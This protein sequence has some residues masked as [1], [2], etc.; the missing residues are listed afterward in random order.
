VG[1]GS[2]WKRVFKKERRDHEGL[3]FG[4]SALISGAKF[5]VERVDP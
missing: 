3:I 1:T 4:A 5:I 2:P